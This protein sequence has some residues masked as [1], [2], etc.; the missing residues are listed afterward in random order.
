MPEPM[1]QETID[2]F[3]KMALEQPEITCGDAPVEILEAAATDV[4]PTPFMEEYFA[5]GHAGWLALKHGR[6]ISLPQNLMDR[7]ILVLWNRASLLDTDL[8]LGQTNPDAGKP[9]F[10]DEGLY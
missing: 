6:K 1:D 2:R 9:F 7:A 3:L 10:S 8:L 5:T 4:E